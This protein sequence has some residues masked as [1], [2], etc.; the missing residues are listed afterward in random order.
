VYVSPFQS[1]ESHAVSLAIESKELLIVN[2]NVAIL[3]NPILFDVS[4]V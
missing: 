2:S 1:N 3:S 4:K